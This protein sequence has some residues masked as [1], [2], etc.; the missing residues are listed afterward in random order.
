MYNQF[1]Q[2]EW[3]NFDSGA[4]NA[5][6]IM[7][8][9]DNCPIASRWVK[10]M[11][12]RE[13]N[14]MRIGT[15]EEGKE[16]VCGTLL[17]APD[18]DEADHNR[19]FH[20]YL[21]KKMLITVNF[22]FDILKKQRSDRV[23]LKLDKVEDAVDG[24]AVL[25][26]GVMNNYLYGID[27]FESKLKKV[28]DE[29]HQRKSSV[30]LKIYDL[31]QSLLKWKSYIL[32]ITEIVKGEEEAFLEKLAVNNEYIRLDKQTQRASYLIK[33]YQE[34]IDTLIHLEEVFSSQ[35]GNEII[36]SL[37]IL[38]VMFTPLTA[39]G[40]LW[41]MNFKMMPE[42]EWPLGYPM[43]LALIILSTIWV[44]LYMKGKGW[45]GQKPKWDRKKN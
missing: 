3:Y 27:H 23:F 19:I 31:R 36:R 39:L 11:N 14:E 8:L 18:P 41:G 12:T 6:K 17:Y 40:A 44:Y 7:E 22:D 21:T 30:L 43:A 13:D 20:Y 24:F 32:P 42:L 1:P 37:T 25:L 45:V 28:L 5:E 9:T 38:T 35:R 26:S 29:V 15:L 2:W 16:L 10:N 4:Q 34:E 33:E